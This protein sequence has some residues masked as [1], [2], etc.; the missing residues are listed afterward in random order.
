M[1]RKVSKFQSTFIA[2]LDNDSGV[3]PVA[4]TVTGGE[5]GYE[6][7]AKMVV[8]AGLALILQKAECPGAATG[9]F[10][11]PAA[12]MGTALIRRLDDA[13][14]HF[15]VLGDAASTAA[16]AVASFYKSAAA[17]L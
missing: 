16:P 6:E 2:E 9:G 1:Q 5:A 15:R 7:T 10:L 3:A 14:I 13:G 4:V 8:E 12:C 17:K 11:S